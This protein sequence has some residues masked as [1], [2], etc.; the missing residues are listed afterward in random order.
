MPPS[1]RK[2]GAARMM[3][4]HLAFA[5][6]ALS[7]SGL[8]TACQPKSGGGVAAGGTKLESMTMGDRKAVV[9]RVDG[10]DITQG[11][12]DDAVR[13]DLVQLDEKIY[14]TKT[15]SLDTVINKRL[16]AKLA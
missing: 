3:S 5:V 8:A 11:E 14:E 6:A 10:E 13:G 4:K 2:P 15:E 1:Q 16:I 12:I 7:L 9:G